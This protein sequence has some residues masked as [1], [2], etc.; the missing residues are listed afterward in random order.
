MGE[1]AR[2]H[3]NMPLHMMMRLERI[4]VAF[5]RK[6]EDAAGMLITAV[7]IALQHEDLA[8]VFP[9]A[10]PATME[11]LGKLSLRVKIDRGIKQVLRA[12]KNDEITCA[13]R[14]CRQFLDYAMVTVENEEA[15]RRGIISFA[16]LKE[17]VQKR[18]LAELVHHSQ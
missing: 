2:Q 18:L 1:S 3:F 16:L 9:P 7:I 15:S 17:L 8:G 13:A 4:S 12:L 6:Q 10:T 11:H 5:G 14:I